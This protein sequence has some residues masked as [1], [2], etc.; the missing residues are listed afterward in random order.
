MVLTLWYYSQ[1]SKVVPSKILRNTFFFVIICVFACLSIL[2]LTPL[3]YGK[4]IQLKDNHWGIIVEEI[5]FLDWARFLVT[6]F[7][8]L[9][10]TLFVS[11]S[12]YSAIDRR[13]KPIK[14]S[15][16]VIIVLSLSLS[17]YQNYWVPMF[18]SFTV[19][20]NESFTSFWG[21]LFFAWAFSD[22]KL[23][24]IEP[25]RAVHDII[26][27]MTNLMILCN[28]YF[29]IQDINQAAQLFFQ[30]NLNQIQNLPIEAIIQNE[31]WEYI[32]SRI[33]IQANQFDKEELEIA[34]EVDGKLRHLLLVITPYMEQNRKV[35]YIFIGTDLTAIEQALEKER[36][37]AQLQNRFVSIASH[38]FR[39]PL[40]AIKLNTTLLKRYLKIDPKVSENKLTR[41]IDRIETEVDRLTVLMDDVLTLGKLES[42][43]MNVQMTENDL[44]E[45]ILELL[46]HDFSFQS[47]GR[48]MQLFVQTPPQKVITDKKVIEHIL[49]NLISNAFKYSPNEQEP[50]I[51]VFFE[52]DHFK[53]KIIDFG[54]GIP[55]KDQGNLFKPFYR[56]SNTVK[57]Q[58]SG[59][60]LVIVKELVSLIQGK[61]TYESHEGEGSQFTITFKQNV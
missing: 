15:L 44:V 5:K 58:G 46:D 45:I 29:Q 56:G 2:E 35:G 16:L 59:L 57:M 11:Y 34:I 42:K 36:Q 39:T 54:I 27:S 7:A 31:N 30:K 37:V 25:H 17:L 43:K 38:Q 55:K 28:N 22:L 40:T 21:M 53:I 33:Y 12:Y 26:S 24:K 9:C 47:D 61:I 48:K 52:Q 1:F 49:I 14:L 13:E 4:T 10:A 19:L 8:Y 18:S 51:H 60:G 23:F 6:A 20:N 32:K 3:H 41:F 50:E